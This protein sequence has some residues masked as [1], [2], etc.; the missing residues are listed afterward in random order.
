MSNQSKAKSSQGQRPNQVK[1]KSSQGQRQSQF[2]AKP[3]Q[4]QLSQ[5]HVTQFKSNQVK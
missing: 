4:S 3:S 1:V 2:K 5:S